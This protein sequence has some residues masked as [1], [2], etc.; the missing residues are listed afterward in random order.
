MPQTTMTEEETT[1]YLSAVKRP[2]EHTLQIFELYRSG[3]VGLNG[4]QELMFKYANTPA[5]HELWRKL[6][7]KL[8]IS[9]RKA[10]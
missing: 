4:A 9:S 7:R 5:H 1:A 8:V 3:Y 6:H 2:D 10:A